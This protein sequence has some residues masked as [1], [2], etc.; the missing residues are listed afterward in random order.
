MNGLQGWK[1]IYSEDG[2]WLEAAKAINSIGQVLKEKGVT[3]GF[4]RCAEPTF[5]F[6]SLLFL[7]LPIRAGTFKKPLFDEDGA[8]TIGIETVDGTQYFADKVVLAAG[9]WS[10]TLVD[11]EGQCCSKVNIAW[12]LRQRYA[13]NCTSGLGIRAY[14][15]DTRRGCRIQRVSC[16]VQ[17]GT[18]VLLRA[19]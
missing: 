4:G 13:A 6:T 16:G 9:A 19:Q 15:V 3:F 10:P 11:L 7:T 18:R 14:A 12:L 8:T 17:L 5:C 1:A 2:G